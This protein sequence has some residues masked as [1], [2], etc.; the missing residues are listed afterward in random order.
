MS[1]K[2]IPRGLRLRLVADS[3]PARHRK[4]RWNGV[5]YRWEFRGLQSSIAAPRWPPTGL[6]YGDPS[7][8]NFGRRIIGAK[9]AAIHRIR[10]IRAA[11]RHARPADAI[12]HHALA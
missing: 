11:L 3:R 6:C 1:A 8:H 10:S 9:A 2:K 5:I 12:E 4:T 7:H